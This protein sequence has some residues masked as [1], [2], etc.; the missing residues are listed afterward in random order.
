[1]QHYDVIIL[2]G[3]LVGLTFANL[4]AEK[5][6]KVVVIEAN[7]LT[8]DWQEETD[9][10]CSAITRASKTLFKSLG[11]WEAITHHKVSPYCRMTVWD[12]LGFGEI[13]F[14]AID[15]AEPDLGHIIENRV[16]LKALLEKTLQHPNITFLAPTSPTALQVEP[17]SVRLTLSDNTMLSANVMVGADGMHSWLRETVNIPVQYEDYHQKALVANVTTEN[18]HAQTAWQRFLPEGPLAFLP[19]LEKNKSSIVWTSTP[20]KIEML[21]TLPP[22]QFCE[23]LG[24][25]LDY[26]LGTIVATSKRAAFPVC[27]QHAKQY[28]QERVALIGDAAH[29]IHPLA[30]QGVNLGFLDAKVL[31][32][33]LSHAKENGYD[34]GNR[35]VLRRY[36]RARKGHNGQ[37][38]TSMT[39]FKKLFGLENTFAVGVR[40]LGLDVVNRSIFLKKKIIK[41]AQT[42]AFL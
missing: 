18:P 12:K 3:G 19:L 9:L 40:S 10:R 39:L 24:F 27:M 41:L 17:N 37:V 13:T 36:E 25:A 1:M 20:E 31:A 22:E 7:P 4:C 35:L 29:V 8:L 38:A 11:C 23:E 42:G 32:N 30:G 16:I 5:T 33:V 6:L 28:V 21:L 26:R 34:I 15:V 14:D 2:G